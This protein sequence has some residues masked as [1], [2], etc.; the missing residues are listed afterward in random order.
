MF[1]CYVPIAYTDVFEMMAW[2]YYSL[3]SRFDVD[4]LIPIFVFFG[5]NW[6]FRRIDMADR[7]KEREFDCWLRKGTVN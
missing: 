4:Q 1:M 6:P 5:Q 2:R 3:I 7:R